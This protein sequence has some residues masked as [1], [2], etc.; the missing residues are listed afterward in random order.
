M[1]QAITDTGV[2]VT[3]NE[4]G[5]WSLTDGAVTLTQQEGFRAA[6]WGSSLA[7][8]KYAE[9]VE[10]RKEGPDYLDLE[11]KLG[12]FN[13]LAAYILV[14]DKLVRGKYR[15]LED[16]SNTLKYLSTYD[17]LSASAS[18]KYG[19]PIEEKTYWL[20]DLYKSDRRQWGTAVARGHL[21]KFTTWETAGTKITL[22]VLGQNS[23]PAV[24]IEY[25]AKA[26]EGVEEAAKEAK[27]VS[28][29]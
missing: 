14:N 20:N 28:D 25:T 21:S 8:C 24:V 19:S 27:L 11:V 15:I 5:T 9:T 3:L 23:G 22:A 26:F 4:N 1:M 12:G 16:Y 7:Q 18:K 17:D 13:A 29:L 2:S 10:I 6:A